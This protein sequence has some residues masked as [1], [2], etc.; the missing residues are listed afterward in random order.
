MAAFD[1]VDEE[2]AAL[3]ERGRRRGVRVIAARR[4]AEVLVDGRWLVSFS[5]NDYLGLSTAPAVVAAAR[6]ALEVEGVGAGA[7]RLITGTG[8]EVAALERELAAFHGAPAALVF[9]S[10]YAANTGVIPALVGRGDA[11]FSDELDHASIIDGCRLSRAEVRVWRHGDVDDLER[12]LAGGAWRRRLVVTESIFS[13]DGDRAPLEAIA[14]VARAREA[15]LMVDDA[16]AV[17]VVGPGGRGHGQ[18]VGADLMVGT[19]GKAFGTAGAYVVGAANLVEYLWNR[20]RSLVFSTAQPPAIAAASRAAL[21]VIASAEGAEL[22]RRALERAAAV[23]GGLAR[24]GLRAPPPAATIIPLIVGDDRRA[25]A[26]MDALLER[27]VLVH[28]I[29]PPTVPDGTARLRIAVSA[30]H[31]SDDV[32]RLL[33]GLGELTARGLLG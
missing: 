33:A 18:E 1:F 4:G 24:L 19:M 11:V 8:G 10:G 22:R 3:T 13:M 14:R 31:S 29:R 7:S 27:G 9:G 30:S 20:C 17:G 32:E 16:H 28:A 6:R 2:L 15:M 21:A 5:S 12:Q 23:H 26:C 25:V